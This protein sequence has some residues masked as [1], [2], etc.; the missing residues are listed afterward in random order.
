[1][2]FGLSPDFIVVELLAA[3]E[4]QFREHAHHHYEWMVERKA[5]LIE[6]THCKKEESERRERERLVR[7]ERERVRG[8]MAAAAALRR[9]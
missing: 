7:V 8:L 9:A 5:Q 4:R 3:A 2:V 1:V 6:E